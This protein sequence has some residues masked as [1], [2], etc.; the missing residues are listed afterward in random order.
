MAD[1]IV[2][3]CIRR[4]AITPSMVRLITMVAVLGAA[5]GAGT[6]Y[7]AGPLTRQPV[8][9]ATQPASLIASDVEW[10]I[11]TTM[12][13]L[14][15]EADWAPLDADFAAG[16]RALGAG[17][18]KT[19]IAAFE[20]AAVREPGNAD[21]HNYIGYAYRRLHEPEHAL[22]HFEAAIAVNPRHRAA[23]QHAG[24]YYASIGKLAKAREH[25]AALD[26][27]CLIPCAEHADLQTAINR[28]AATAD[29]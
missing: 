26:R 22:A 12:G 7:F 10:P 21:I 20:L 1:G 17:E 27:I 8:T 5:V 4:R 24:E 6:A 25:L 28:F 18:W 2:G 29:R 14:D 3:R 23:H 11:C 13:S 16:K 15:G 9:A 19:A